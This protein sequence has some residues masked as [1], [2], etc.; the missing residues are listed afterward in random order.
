M[1]PDQQHVSP[2]D[3]Q[4]PAH[5]PANAT[6]PSRRNNRKIAAIWLLVGPSALI[7]LSVL[8]YA[9]VNLIFSSTT[10]SDAELFGQQPIAATITN[11]ALFVAGTI[12][13]IAWLPSIII[14]IVLLATKKQQ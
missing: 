5:Q 9:L 10:N 3:T 12:G 14:G 11:I 4:A 8:A 1:N 7:I 2:T 13:V 6:Q